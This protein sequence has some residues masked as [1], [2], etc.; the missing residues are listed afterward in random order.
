MPH[1]SGEAGGA[2]DRAP[3]VVGTLA[4]VPEAVVE[5]RADTVAVVPSVG[6]T[7]STLRRLGWALE[8]SG[9]DLVVAPSLTDVAGPRVHIRPVAGLPL[10][11][12]EEPQYEGPMR[13]VKGLVDRAAALG[14]LLLLSPVLLGVALVVRGTSPGPAFFRQERVG[15][16]GRPFVLCKFRSM[17]ADAEARKAQLADA[18]EHDG[19]LFKMRADPRVT[20][21][22]RWLRRYSLDELPQL[23]NVLKGDMSLVGPRPLIEN[24]DRQVE[25]RFRQRLASSPGLTGPWQIHGRSE[26]PFEEM[27]NLD[28]LYVMNWSLWGD[29]KLML[30]TV[31]A[32]VRGQGA[33]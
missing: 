33:Y 9:V 27:I 28:Y 4:T 25:G 31:H 6:I 2:R 19:V 5:T 30:R 20:P 29:V 12:V 13:V 1:Q 15:R 11:H 3:R 23:I 26:I 24:E 7:P 32:I 22:G 14:L 17:V 10:L 18:N 16:E 8:G 21:V